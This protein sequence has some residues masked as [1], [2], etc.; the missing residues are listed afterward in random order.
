MLDNV[1]INEN[2]YTLGKIK[3]LYLNLLMFDT[4][5]YFIYTR[6]KFDGVGQKANI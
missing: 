2:V 6:N 4:N 3:E 1:H 5:V